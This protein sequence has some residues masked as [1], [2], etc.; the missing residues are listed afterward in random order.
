MIE[1]NCTWEL[2]DRPSDKNIIGVKWIF[3]TKLN[4]DITINKHKTRLIVKGYAQIYGVDYS[5][6]FAPVARMD[7]IKFLFVVA[8]YKNWK[9]FLLDVNSDQTECKQHH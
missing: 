8:V 3:R 6:T 9:V 4:A 7:T 5:D 2:V 1:K